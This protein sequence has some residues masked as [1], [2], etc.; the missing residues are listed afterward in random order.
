MVA[1]LK[2]IYEPK[3]DSVIMHG[4]EV[5]SLPIRDFKYFVHNASQVARSL[6]IQT[7][8]VGLTNEHVRLLKKYNVHVGISVDGPPELN[9]LRGPRDPEKNK[10]YQ[11]DVVSNM[12]KLQKNGISFGVLSV[13]SK[14]N[15]SKDNIEK[16]ISWYKS[17]KISGRF[18]P[19]FCPVWNNTLSEYQLTPDEAKYAWI[20]LAD[21][22][23]KDHTLQWLPAREFIDNLFGAYSLSSCIVNR[24]DYFVA[25]CRAILADGSVA[26]C[27]RT[28]Q[29]GY[30]LRN[31]S[32]ERKHTRSDMLSQT[33][34]A[35]CRYFPIC[36]GGCPGEG[37][38]GDFRHRSYFCEAYYGL[39]EYLEDRIRGLMPNVVL[40]IDRED[41]YN[42]YALKGRY[43]QWAEKMIN[44]S[45]WHHITN[46]KK[47]SPCS[48]RQSPCSQ[49]KN[50][51]GD[52]YDDIRPDHGDHYDEAKPHDHGNWSD[53]GDSR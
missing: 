53:H 27:D 42:E 44:H 31:N 39:Y 25:T 43:N 47:Q 49:Q 23:L 20:R 50:E 12:A 17:N 19:M 51:H 5:F 3:N 2:E 35:E 52:H 24:C 40:S 34:C 11:Q 4:G 28:F 1:T 21:E 14:V 48:Q 7:S 15:A 45:T 10:Q 30:Y 37:D 16:L 13:L 33:E 18:N 26:S 32:E 22:V 9:I 29:E 46:T 36:G 41:Y 38:D 8:L 6:S